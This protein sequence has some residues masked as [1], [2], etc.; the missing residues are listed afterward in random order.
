MRKFI[1][2]ARVDL[3][4]IGVLVT[5]DLFIVVFGGV[6]FPWRN[7][8]HNC[9]VDA[10]YIPMIQ[11]FWNKGFLFFFP[12]FSTSMVEILMFT[13]Q[14]SEP[15]FCGKFFLLSSKKEEKIWEGN[16]IVNVKCVLHQKKFQNIKKTQK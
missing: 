16:Q 8:L 13:V 6:Y 10:I 1:L 9:Y 7:P 5:C 14:P 2:K 11:I 12:F 15:N 3:W 4:A